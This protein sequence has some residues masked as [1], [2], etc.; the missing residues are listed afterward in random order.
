M[1]AIVWRDAL[2]VYLLDPLSCI[3][4]TL[5]FAFTSREFGSTQL[6]SLSRKAGWQD[7][8]LGR[9]NLF[10]NEIEM[11]FFDDER[12][13]G[14]G[15]TYHE[16]ATTVVHVSHAGSMLQER[17]LAS[18]NLTIALPRVGRTSLSW[19]LRMQ[20]PMFHVAQRSCS[21]SCIFLVVA[22]L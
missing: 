3:D 1:L 5:P 9:S 6:I 22:K 13:K 16:T 15:G 17:S 20:L 12:P 10:Y 8:I 18:C 19:N 4:E 7:A 21:Q 14:D 2:V 11:T